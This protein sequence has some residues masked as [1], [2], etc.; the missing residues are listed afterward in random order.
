MFSFL[1]FKNTTCPSLNYHFQYHFKLFLS[2]SYLQTQIEWLKHWN[3]RCDI[4]GTSVCTKKKRD[5][6]NLYDLLKKQLKWVTEMTVN[7]TTTSVKYNWSQHAS[8]PTAT[9]LSCQ[10]SSALIISMLCF[11]SF[12]IKFSIITNTCSLSHFFFSLQIEIVVNNEG[13]NGEM[14]KGM[15]RWESSREREK[16]HP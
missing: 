12:N 9:L 11:V 6:V 14:I 5:E 15:K 16:N 10:L 8:G 3:A 1:F 13:D 4:K 2:I 7:N